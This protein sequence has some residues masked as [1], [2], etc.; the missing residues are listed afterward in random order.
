MKATCPTH[1]VELVDG[2]CSG[3]QED[4]NLAISQSKVRDVTISGRL[5]T[6][7]KVSVD[8]KLIDYRHKTTYVEVS[9]PLSLENKAYDF[10]NKLIEEDAG[11]CGCYTCILERNSN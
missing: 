10:I 2:A 4:I 5:S 6:P 8:G 9:I 11:V 7:S 3:C 1:E